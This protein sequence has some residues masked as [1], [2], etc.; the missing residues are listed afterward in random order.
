MIERGNTFESKES[1][2]F[3]S[4]EVI[5]VCGSGLQ[6]NNG[7]LKKWWE[8]KPEAEL[9]K[10]SWDARM[11]LTAA[12][13]L[14]QRYKKNGKEIPIIVTGGKEAY[15]TLAPSIAAVMKEDLR[16][17]FEVPENLIIEIDTGGNTVSDM[18]AVVKKM[19]ELGLHLAITIS[20]DY[21]KLAEVLAKKKGMEFV[22]AERLLEERNSRYQKIIEDIYACP[23]MKN[24]KH[25]QSL[26]S[27]IL[28]LPLGEKIY[29][30]WAKRTLPK[31]S[32]VTVFDPYGL[33]KMAGKFNK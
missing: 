15:S 2:V 30:W 12:G 25:S 5:I 10:S 4:L 23:T 24:L 28:I 11:R 8:G 29:N 26:M 27:H 22:S 1:A 21:H 14:W 19:E 9:P 20:S 16:R 18:E 7:G 13:E 3:S 17:R 6:M 31:R 33:Q 32:P